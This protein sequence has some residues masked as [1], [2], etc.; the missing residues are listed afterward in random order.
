VNF[1]NWIRSLFTSSSKVD[2]STNI[3]QPAIFVGS[4]YPEVLMTTPNRTR[5]RS[6]SP[7]GVV[8]H[9]SCGSWD[10]D[11][12]WIMKSS[13]P[14]RGIYASYHCLIRQDG[15]RV[16]FGKDTDRMWH[17]GV[18]RWNGRSSCND[19][20][21]GCAFSGSTYPNEKFGGLLNK[22]QIES[23]LEWLQPRWEKWKFSS[24]WMTDHR[25]ASPGRKNDLNP[26][27]WNK[28]YEAIKQR[29]K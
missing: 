20:M 25:Q 13:N 4:K 11:I 24:K 10:G 9:H 16:V 12:G 23:A 29:F 1:F 7:V 15:E 27:E 26:S 19:F 2:K 8:F 5:G 3:N 6:I 18:S 17:A 22:D 21:L 14:S 28:L